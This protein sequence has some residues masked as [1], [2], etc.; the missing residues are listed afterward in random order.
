MSYP[1]MQ[2]PQPDPDERS[3][4]WT[5]LTVTIAIIGALCV[6]VVFGGMMLLRGSPAETASQKDLITF[7]VQGTGQAQVTWTNT[8]LSRG[9]TTVE[10]PWTR[11]VSGP[12][13]AG[14]SVTAVRQATDNGA[15][16]CQ[17]DEG[18]RKVVSRTTS[19]PRATVIC[20]T[21]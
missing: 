8:K 3:G 15:I 7:R 5:A 16:T 14:V 2:P 10:L 6:A 1:V 21:G 13:I 12:A 9:P 19:G 17:I 11:R 4:W 20:A 18:T